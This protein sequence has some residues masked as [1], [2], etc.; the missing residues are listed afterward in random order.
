MLLL[1]VQIVLFAMMF[2]LM[3]PPVVHYLNIVVVDV[4]VVVALLVALGVYSIMFVVV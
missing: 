2:G 1:C 4:V 3:V